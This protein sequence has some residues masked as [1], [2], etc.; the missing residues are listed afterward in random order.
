MQLCTFS[1]GLDFSSSLNHRDRSPK[2]PSTRLSPWC[3]P[4]KL[5]CTGMD[6]LSGSSRRTVC[7]N[8]SERKC[9]PQSVQMVSEVRQGKD[10]SVTKSRRQSL[11]KRL[12]CDRMDE[13]KSK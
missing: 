12:S 9:G 13:K 10:R 4:K 3:S 1:T 6:S 11:T 2:W 5:H 8:S 7:A